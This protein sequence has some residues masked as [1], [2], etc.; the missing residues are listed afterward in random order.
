MSKGPLN[1]TSE[2]PATKT[3]AEIT[4]I[5]RQHGAMHIVIH[6][7]DQQEPAGL[8]F[9]VRTPIGERGFDM[10]VDAHKVLRVLEKRRLERNLRVRPPDLDQARRTAWRVIKDW[11]AGQLA[12]YE[13]DLVSL[14]QVMLAYMHTGPGR[15]LYADIVENRLLLQK[16]PEE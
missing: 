8:G 10:P 14:D 16:P 2:V 3:I 5:L 1:Y 12:I 4:E 15:T 7:D 13:W 9:Y 11:L 6:Y